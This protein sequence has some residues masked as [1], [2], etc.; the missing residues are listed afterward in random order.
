MTARNG[1]AAASPNQTQADSDDAASLST[2]NTCFGAVRMWADKSSVVR[3]EDQPPCEL[4]LRALNVLKLLAA[5]MTGEDPPRHWLPPNEFLRQVTFQR[6][7]RARNCGPLTA[8]E[9]IRWAGSRG[10]T[11]ARPSWAGQSFSQMWRCLEAR[12]A[13]G[14]PVQAAIVEALD[15]S[16][17]R[18][19]TKIPVGVQRVLL[20]LLT[21]GS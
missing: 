5:E 10:V 12:F 4:S 11:I 1:F 20:K 18:K 3:P 9:I 19:S 2:V 8:D 16:V 13:A 6:L 15:R 14:E 7:S 21:E 17:R